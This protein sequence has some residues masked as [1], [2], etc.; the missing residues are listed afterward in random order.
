[1]FVFVH[2]SACTL[3]TELVALFQMCASSHSVYNTYTTTALTD[4]GESERG[5][6]STTGPCS[7]PCHRNGAS[8]TVDFFVCATHPGLAL[9]RWT[10]RSA[11]RLRDPQSIGTWTER[12]NWDNQWPKEGAFLLRSHLYYH[13]T[14]A[15]EMQKIILRSTFFF[16]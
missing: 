7:S 8:L 12:T 1:M 15:Q 6:A 9:S 5:D 11:H 10:D 16:S 3:E 4:P 14:Q 2:L 13:R